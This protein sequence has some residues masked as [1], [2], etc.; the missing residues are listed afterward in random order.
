MG[1]HDVRLPTQFSVGSLFG[2]SFNTKIISLDSGAEFRIGTGP[3]AGRRSY[4]LERGIDSLSSL[5]TLYEF[6]VARSGALNSFRLKD[7]LDYAT[8]P[9]GTTHLPKDVPDVVTN[10][11]EDLVL[12]SGNTYQ[13]V[14]RYVSGSQTIVRT[15]TK[16]V[17]GTALVRDD[18]GPLT[19]G[20]TWD[21]LNGRVTLAGAPTGT[22][23]GGCEF[24]VPV[25]F[26]EETDRAFLI[27][28]DAID[29]GS[30]PEI[31]CVEDV[32]PVTVSQDFPY[33]GALNHGDIGGNVALSDLSAKVHVA[34]PTTTGKKF[35]LPD[36]SNMPLGGPYF[37]VFNAGTQAMEVENHLGTDVVNP[38]AIS[39]GNTLW[40]G[41]NSAGTKT[42]YAT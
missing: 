12:V 4:S 23:T 21:Y 28:I 34:A 25:R 1:F 7:W 39:S 2:P 33:G 30:L 24:D 41:V 20:L 10:T 5:Y 42:W 36:Y 13:F 35:I 18:T 38:L 6:F 37:M 22:V 16:L 19:A 40:L 11:D 15:L 9:S 17:A 14:K 8:T 26:A 31:R 29:T 3:D 32:D 27:A